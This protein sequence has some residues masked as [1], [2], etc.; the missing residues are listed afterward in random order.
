[1]S[2]KIQNPRSYTNSK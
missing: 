2:E 1:M